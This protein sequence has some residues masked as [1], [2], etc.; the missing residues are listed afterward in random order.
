MGRREGGEG[1]VGGA[2]S[3]TLGYP[4]KNFKGQVV[5]LLNKGIVPCREAVLISE[6]TLLNEETT[7]C[8]PL[9]RGCSYFRGL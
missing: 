9:Y 3:V 2:S 7:F 6:V 4:E 5:E 8:C 1:R